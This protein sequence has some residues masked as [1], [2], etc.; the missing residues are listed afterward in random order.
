MRRYT[1]TLHTANP[2][3]LFSKEDLPFR[4]F[5]SPVIVGT[6]DSGAGGHGGHFPEQ[7]QSSDDRRPKGAGQAERAG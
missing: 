3:V 2:M 1:K 5:V 6:L 7:R 4:T